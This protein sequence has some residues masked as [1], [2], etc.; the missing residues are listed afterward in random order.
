MTRPVSVSFFA[1]TLL[2]AAAS[3][4]SLTG[5]DK[6][7]K[8]NCAGGV[9]TVRGANNDVTVSGSCKSLT[10]EG[11]ENIIRIDLAASSKIIIRGADNTVYWTA[12]KGSKP[13]VNVIGADNIVQ[14]TR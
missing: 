3:G 13:V 2:I 1:A 14:R 11:A 8:L 5:A 6:T 9:A 10:L 12:P 4:A 7:A